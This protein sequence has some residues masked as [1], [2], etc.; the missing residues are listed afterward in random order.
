[1]NPELQDMAGKLRA[2][3]LNDYVDWCSALSHSSIPTWKIQYL[4]VYG[5]TTSN[6]L[7][8]FS[9]TIEFKD[10]DHHRL[11]IPGDQTR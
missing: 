7:S 2:R 1:M 10:S 9:R 5:V 11:D 3:S 4:R 8:S 6:S